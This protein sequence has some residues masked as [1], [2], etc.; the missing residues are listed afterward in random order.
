MGTINSMTDTQTLTPSETVPTTPEEVMKDVLGYGNIPMDIAEAKQK[1]RV[2]AHK[3]YTKYVRTGADLEINISHKTKK[4]LFKLKLHDLDKWLSQTETQ[5]DVNLIYH[6]FDE[7]MEEMFA[8]MRSSV[9]LFVQTEEY[10]SIV[11]N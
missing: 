1:L 5:C 9:G 6:L 3:L 7:C 11:C 8:L 4:K 2:I 10:Q